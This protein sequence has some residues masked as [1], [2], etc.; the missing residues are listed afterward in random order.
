[1]G[2]YLDEAYFKALQELFPRYG[3]TLPAGTRF[4]QEGDTDTRVYFLLTGLAAVF[5]SEAPDDHMLWMLE[6]GDFVGELA[7]L[8]HLPRSASV[9]TIEESHLVV[10]N[11]ELF[12]GLISSYPALAMK[13]IRTMG[14][15]M[16]KL[17]ARYK[18]HLGYKP[19]GH[20]YVIS[21]LDEGLPLPMLTTSGER[22][23]G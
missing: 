13:V 4:I 8:D 21:D 6:A 15:R 19:A 5:I 18:L 1:M 9:E 7:M 14:K 16:R 22:D 11:Q 23:S 2:S 20:D 12:A 3:V 17:D 10:L